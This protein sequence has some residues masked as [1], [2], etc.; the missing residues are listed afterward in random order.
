MQF[1]VSLNSRSTPNP[2]TAMNTRKKQQTVSTG[3]KIVF[4]FVGSIL[5]LCIIEGFATSTAICLE[6]WTQWSERP[7]VVNLR[8]ESHCQYDEEL[9]WINKPDTTLA[10]FYGP[11]LSISINHNGLRG[12]QDFDPD[13]QHYKIICLGDSFT[14]GY[15]VGDQQTIPH[16]LQ[17]QLIEGTQVANMGQGGYSIGQSWLWL[18][19]IGPELKPNLVVCIFI[20]EDFRRLATNRTANG[21]STPQFDVIEGR[22]EVS[23][24]PVPPKLDAGTYL[25]GHVQFLSTLKK[26]SSLARGIEGLASSERSDSDADDEVLFCGLM[27]LK[28]I[29]QEC[30]TMN[31]KLVVVLTPTL[32]DANDPTFGARYKTCSNVMAAFLQREQIPFL[33]LLSEFD[34]RQIGSVY[35]DEA[36]HHYNSNGNQLVANKLVEWLPKIVP[37]FQGSVDTRGPSK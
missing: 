14:L 32:S 9:G 18:K 27:V 17:Q 12:L 30:Q 7:K 20:P 21:Y 24:I 34:G 2:T 1:S 6:L 4:A 25:P 19:R 31:S 13:S 37:E 15:G 28:S 36:F 8:E 23:N 22:V 11:G 33:D 35:L 29:A 16:H 26:H 5:G 10:D 3:K